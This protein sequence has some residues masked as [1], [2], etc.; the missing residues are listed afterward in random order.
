MVM[1]RS[2]A[3]AEPATRRRPTEL[4]S[5]SEFLSLRPPLRKSARLN[6]GLDDSLGGAHNASDSVSVRPPNV[7]KR[8]A[9]ISMS[10]AHLS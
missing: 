8:L 9:L 5:S 1:L 2:N 7:R 10:R 4:D 3:A 6:R